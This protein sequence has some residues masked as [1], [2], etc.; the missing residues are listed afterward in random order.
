MLTLLWCHL[1][2]ANR[3]LPCPS[4]TIQLQIWLQVKTL[5]KIIWFGWK[6]DYYSL[7][8]TCTCRH[9]LP[10]AGNE[11]RRKERGHFSET[12]ML[13]CSTPSWPPVRLGTVKFERTTRQTLRHTHTPLMND[14][15]NLLFSMHNST[16]RRRFF[17]RLCST[18]LIEGRWTSC[19]TKRCDYTTMTNTIQYGSYN[20]HH[21]QTY[22]A[23]CSHSN[24]YRI[25]AYLTQ[26]LN[27]Q[28][29][30]CHSSISLNP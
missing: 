14:T 25:L 16:S 10:R 20:N 5:H 3:A 23:A 26:L 13:V 2:R 1:L 27:V 22:T 17:K 29:L 11:I 6:S 24:L 28:R 8:P 12:L 30:V 7:S 19:S 15:H 9:S 21:C 18:E 4:F